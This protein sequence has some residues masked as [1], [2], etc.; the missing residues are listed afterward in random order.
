MGPSKSKPSGVETVAPDAPPDPPVFPVEPTPQEDGPIGPGP[1]TLPP[2]EPGPLP[3]PAEEIAG[4]ISGALSQVMKPVDPSKVRGELIRDVK[5]Q[6]QGVAPEWPEVGHCIVTDRLGRF[7]RMLPTA[8]VMRP[9][10]RVVEVGGQ[11]RE[12]T[13]GSHFDNVQSGQW[14]VECFSP[15]PQ[16]LLELQD[17]TRHNPVLFTG[18]NEYERRGDFWVHPLFRNKAK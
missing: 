11:G 14:I 3:S 13:P 1:V 16:A 8:A 9:Q 5:A 2:F 12:I 17:G 7:R 4:A 18:A 10:G 15:H 6:P